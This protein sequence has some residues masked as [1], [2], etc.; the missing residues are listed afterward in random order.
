MKKKK[1]TCVCH[2]CAVTIEI[3]VTGTLTGDK[4]SKFTPEICPFCGDS[5]DLEENLVAK[6]NLLEIQQAMLKERDEELRKKQKED[7][8]KSKKMFEELEALRKQGEEQRVRYDAQAEKINK[9]VNAFEEQCGRKPS[10]D[11]VYDNFKD[12]IDSDILDRFLDRY[13][14]NGDDFV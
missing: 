4:R 7:N 9:Y 11:E 2:E 6:N 3:V 14:N 8:E 5:V 12:D 10:R 1:Q 13:Q